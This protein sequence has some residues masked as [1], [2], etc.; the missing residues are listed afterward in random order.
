MYEYIS[1][2]PVVPLWWL[3]TKTSG[4][5]YTIWIT[6]D[7]NT[8][9][10]EQRKPSIQVLQKPLA[11]KTAR[12]Q[13]AGHDRILILLGCTY[14]SKCIQAIPRYQT[15]LNQERDP[16]PHTKLHDLVTIF[17]TILPFSFHAEK[18]FYNPHYPFQKWENKNKKKNK[19]KKQQW[20]KFY[21]GTFLSHSSIRNQVMGSSCR[22]PY[23]PWV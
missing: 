18:Q 11:Q 20:S 19:N 6:S 23:T 14:R 4:F 7:Q 8:D 3:V 2:R 10:C 13:S 5:T 15:N 21:E 16:K 17:H 22:F 12:T 1:L 9:A